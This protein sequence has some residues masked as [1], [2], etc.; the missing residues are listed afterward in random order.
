MSEETKRQPSEPEPGAEEKRHDQLSRDIRVTGLTLLAYSIF[1]FVTLS[2]VD[3]IIRTR[4]V[5]I[6]LA[7]F[8]IKFSSFLTAGPVVLIIIA[9]YLHLFIWEWEKDRSVAME[10]KLPFTFNMENLA[11]QILSGLIFYILPPVV[12]LF[13]SYR[14]YV[15]AVDLIDIWGIAAFLSFAGLGLLFWKHTVNRVSKIPGVKKRSLYARRILVTGFVFIGCSLSALAV[16][17]GLN[18]LFPLDLVRAD[19]SGLK[20]AQ[21]NLNNANLLAAN[22]KEAIFLRTSLKGANLSDANLEKADLAGINLKGAN[23][24]KANLKGA[25]LEKAKLNKVNFRRANLEG[26]NLRRARFNGASLKKANL[27]GALIAGTGMAEVINLTCK[28]LNSANVF[29]DYAYGSKKYQT[30]LPKYLEITRDSAGGLKECF[31]LQSQKKER[32]RLFSLD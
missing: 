10:R 30:L 7:D 3:E 24:N 32:E 17:G 5:E 18:R 12:L 4:N 29:S 13:F 2:Q 28:Q 9:F 21:L 25:N 31:Q 15:W 27:H 11:A 1:C 14:A 23:L 8:P 19:L 20:I 26:A 22:L 16:S 6:P